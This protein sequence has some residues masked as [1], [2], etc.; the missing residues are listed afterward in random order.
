MG[1]SMSA[2]DMVSIGLLLSNGKTDITL[3]ELFGRVTKYQIENNLVFGVDEQDFSSS[4]AKLVFLELG[5]LN[6]NKIDAF[7]KLTF[8][9]IIPVMLKF[10][11]VYFNDEGEH[12][13]KEIGHLDVKNDQ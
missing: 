2:A 9:E 1:K 6:L 7:F 4:I 10:K 8:K 3:E 12:W 11:E 13:I 5:L